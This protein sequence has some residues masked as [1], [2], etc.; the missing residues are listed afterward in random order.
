MGTVNVDNNGIPLP[1]GVAGNHSYRDQTTKERE[2]AAFGEVSYRF[3][4][5]LKATAG[6]R[7]SKTDVSYLQYTGASVFG[8]TLG[9]VGTP[10]APTS[11]H[12]LPAPSRK[13]QA[14]GIA[15]YN[16]VKPQPVSTLY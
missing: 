3:T 15:E 12:T 14:T 9:F 1:V 16:R 10:G 2:L 7:Y 6:M 11:T 13:G 8:N 5:T 4:D